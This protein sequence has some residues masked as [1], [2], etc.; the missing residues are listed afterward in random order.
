VDEVFRRNPVGQRCV[1]LVSEAVAGLVVV[2]EQGP[3]AAAD[4]A[5]AGD[6][7]ERSAA[8]LLLHGNA[9]A[10]LVPDGHD[11]PAE[12]HSIRP[13]RV[14]VVTGVD[15]WPAAY[16][17]RVGTKLTRLPARDGLGRMQV[18][19]I[20]ALNPVDDHYGQ[21]CLDAAIGAATVHNRALLWNKALLDNG[22]RPTGALVYNPADG[23]NLSPDQFDR[24][25]RELSEQFAGSQHA[26]RPMLLEGGLQWQGLGLSPME[27]DFVALKEAA[28]RD[29][30]LAFGVPPVLVGL[31][32]D[33]TYANAREA[34]RALFRQTVLPLAGKILAHIGT[35]LS[36]WMGPVRL[37][38]DQ[39]R[40]SE[41]AEDRA[42]LWASLGSAEF[43][44]RAEKRAMVGFEPDGESE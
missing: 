41:L 43:L 7:L 28:A 20:R 16:D 1:R 22:A 37:V 5:M 30:A 23:S 9:Y 29:L 8:A 24:L 39:D 40:L 32:G 11:R 13:E 31:P 35:L 2:A 6:L 12:L 15:G 21:G 25:K 19:H 3:E 26:G 10:Q 42:H 4:L 33:S 27:M 18:A 44:T 34:G 36:D 38:V 17:Y 14:A